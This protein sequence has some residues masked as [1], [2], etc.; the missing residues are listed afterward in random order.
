MVDFSQW[1]ARAVLVG[2]VENLYLLMNLDLLSITRML[3]KNY[4]VVTCNWCRPAM[5]IFQTHDME[6]F[7]AAD[8]KHPY[9][10]IHVHPADRKCFAFTIPG[11]GQLQ[12]T[13]M[14]QG[15][16]TASLTMS[17]L[18]LRVLGE[19]PPFE[20]SLLQSITRPAN[21]FGSII[22]FE[23]RNSQLRPKPQPNNEENKLTEF[24]Y[25][26]RVKPNNDFKY[27]YNGRPV[28]LRWHCGYWRQ[29]CSDPILRS[30]VGIHKC[31]DTSQRKHDSQ[32]KKIE[33]L[34][35]GGDAYVQK[36]ARFGD[37]FPARQSGKDAKNSIIFWRVHGGWSSV[38]GSNSFSDRTWCGWI[39]P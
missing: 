23:E 12:P 26:L 5:T 37:I 17:E 11:M 35:L 32:E 36:A 39:P 29:R 14:Q 34:V 10:I 9:S 22:V 30:P 2:K 19:I 8:L 21:G 13:G 7:V 15:S 24:F 28:P 6:I 1:N 33:A 3:W 20:P 25:N 16:M 18:M 38:C 27:E 31:S 4:Q